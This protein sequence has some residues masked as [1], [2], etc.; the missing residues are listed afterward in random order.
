MVLMKKWSNQGGHLTNLTLRRTTVHVLKIDL[1]HAQHFSYS[2]HV[3]Y[4]PVNILSQ[5]F[6]YSVSVLQ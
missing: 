6:C 2:T 5:A 1:L 3:D 4:P